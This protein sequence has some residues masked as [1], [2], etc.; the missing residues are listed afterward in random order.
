MHRKQA[1]E[2]FELPERFFAEKEITEH[3]DGGQEIGAPEDPVGQFVADNAGLA[4]AVNDQ[5][6][7]VKQG[8]YQAAGQIT[9]HNEEKMSLLAARRDR[10]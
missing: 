1:A 7:G 6:N 4:A 9:H 2:H 3:Q 8:K 10:I 5:R